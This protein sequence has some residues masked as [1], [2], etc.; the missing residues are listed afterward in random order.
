MAVESAGATASELKL[1]YLNLLVT[2]MKTQN[3]LEP[4]DNADMTSQLAMLSQLEQTEN[5]N[6]QMGTLNESIEKLNSNFMGAMLLSE[7]QYAKDLIGKSV[8]FYDGQYGQVFSG[9]AVQVNVTQDGPSI[10]VEVKNN[11]RWDDAAEYKTFNVSVPDVT[12][13]SDYT[14]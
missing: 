12:A 8:D 1:D 6:G 3:P 10:A 14:E 2:Q 9:K 7:Y 5:M 13:V 11:G 4:M